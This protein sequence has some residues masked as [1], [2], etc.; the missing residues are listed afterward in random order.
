MKRTCK[1][2]GKEFFISQSEISFYKGRNLQLPRRCKDCRDANKQQPP[3]AKGSGKEERESFKGTE[4]RE[5]QENKEKAGKPVIRE[6]AETTDRVQQAPPSLG[7]VGAQPDRKTAGEAKK[8]GLAMKMLTFA[9]IVVIL[10]VSQMLPKSSG[11]ASPAETAGKVYV[12]SALTFRNEEYLN[13]HYQKHG[14]DMGF[15]SPEEYQT[16][17]AAVVG[18]Q[19]AL[20][21]T[22]AEDGDDVYYIES[23]NEFVVVSTDG[24]IRTYFHPDD[25]IDY[26]NRQ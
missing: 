10:M 1:Q 5:K 3:E 12:D 19:E 7:P 11:S 18:S 17:A 16:A 21:K 23:T 26:F 6:E 24:Y 4:G 9:A 22:E 14:I 15:S 8:P 2:C 13:S 20:H 25:G